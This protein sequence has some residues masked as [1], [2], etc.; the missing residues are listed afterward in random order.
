MI[1]DCA[2]CELRRKAGTNFNEPCRPADGDEAVECNCVEGRKGEIDPVRLR[3]VCNFMSRYC[4][5]RLEE[6]QHRLHQCRVMIL[7]R[8]QSRSDT[9]I[10][11][12]AVA[13]ARLGVYREIQLHKLISAVEIVPSDVLHEPKP[14]LCPLRQ[15]PQPRHPHQYTCY[16]PCTHERHLTL[17]RMWKKCTNGR[18]AGKMAGR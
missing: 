6:R 2:P 12:V 1:D 10:A 9:H 16:L 18:G 13:V 15:G 14:N 7:A 3:F 4:E 8:G 11:G 17:L 5:H